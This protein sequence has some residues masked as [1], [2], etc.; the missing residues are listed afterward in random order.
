MFAGDNN[1]DDIRFGADNQILMQ[2]TNV[3]LVLEP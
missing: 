3:A 2:H 1:P